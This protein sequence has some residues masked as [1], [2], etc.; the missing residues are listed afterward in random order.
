[1]P[2]NQKR[3]AGEKA[4]R[5]EATRKNAVKKYEKLIAEKSNDK[6]VPI[7]KE[8]LAKHK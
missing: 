4:R 5:K 8:L 3:D 7:W 6:Q 2:K 1:M